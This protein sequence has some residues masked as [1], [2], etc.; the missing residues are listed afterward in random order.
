MWPLGCCWG[1]FCTGFHRIAWG[2]GGKQPFLSPWLLKTS[3]FCLNE[4]TLT[5]LMDS[6]PFLVLCPFLTQCNPTPPQPLSNCESPFEESNPGWWMP[7]LC[8][9]EKRAA[10]LDVPVEFAQKLIHSSFGGRNR[11]WME[12]ET[13]V[14]ICYSLAPGLPLWNISVE[15]KQ[16][17][18]SRVIAA[19]LFA[20]EVLGNCAVIW[21]HRKQWA[22]FVVNDVLLLSASQPTATKKCLESKLKS[23]KGKMKRAYNPDTAQLGLC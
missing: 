14:I 7:S 21:N 9:L 15:E 2:G 17:F 20:E 10:L 8:E 4:L 19:G 13:Y 16:V 22:F 6:C 1:H 11:Q 3:L 23:C 5:S 18:S 12:A